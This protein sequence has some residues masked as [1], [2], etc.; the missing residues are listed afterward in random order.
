[1]D[2]YELKLM[3]LNDRDYVD[4]LYDKKLIIKEERDRLIGM[5]DSP[6]DENYTVAR[7]FIDSKTEELHKLVGNKVRKWH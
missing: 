6:D 3:R 1:M 5:I 7:F 2:H 4:F